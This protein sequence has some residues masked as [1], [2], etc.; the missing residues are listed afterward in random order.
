MEEY[1]KK[2]YGFLEDKNYLRTESDIEQWCRDGGSELF[3]VDDGE[4]YGGETTV[5]LYTQDGKFWQVDLEADCEKFH[6]HDDNDWFVFGSITS[7]K[8]QEIEKPE[9]KQRSTFSF[10]LRNATLDEV[11]KVQ[12]FCRENNIQYSD[13]YQS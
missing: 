10:S 13:I 5:N 1:L 6:D 11:A 12:E 9:P 4:F 3:D 7:F 8:Y 2:D